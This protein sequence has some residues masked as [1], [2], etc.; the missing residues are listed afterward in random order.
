MRYFFIYL[1]LA[2]GSISAFSQ[3]CESPFRPIVMVHGFLGGGDNFAPMV[4][5]LSAAGYCTEKLFVFDWNSIARNQPDSLLNRFIDSILRLT[6]SERID[7]IGHSAGGNLAYTFM[8]KAGQAAKVAHYVHIGSSSKQTPPGP[9]GAVPILNLYS[10]NDRVVKGADIPGATNIRF[11]EFDHFELVTA[12]S[13]AQ[14]VYHFLTGGR[15]YKRK[16]IMPLPSKYP[17]AGKVLTLGENNP[18][19]GAKLELWQV[20]KEGIKT[21]KLGETVSSADGGFTFSG[22]EPYQSYL[23]FCKPSSGRQVAY[24]LP[25]IQPEEKWLYIRTLPATGLMTLLLNALP[26]DEQQSAF[27]LFSNQRA[28]INPRDDLKVNDTLLSTATFADPAKT[29]IAWFLYDGNKNNQSDYS[30]IP[31]FN[32]APFMRGIDYRIPAGNAA[33]PVEVYLNGSSYM[34]PAIPSSEAIVIVML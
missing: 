29:A 18:Q 4:R 22:I 2:F 7:L 15:H 16:K 11:Q 8:Q 17:V 30:L 13:I 19:A 26:A 33:R 10:L 25:K 34:V 23:L 32:S 14:W 12:D 24:F 21:G 3:P 5:R 9:D 1:T 31:S 20:N 6:K 28:V 27:V